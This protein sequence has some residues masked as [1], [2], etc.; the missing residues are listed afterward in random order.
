MVIDPNHVWGIDFT[1]IRL[2]NSWMCLVAVLD[3]YSRFVVSWELDQSLEMPFVVTAVDRALKQAVP[4][5]WNSDQGSHFTSSQY[6]DWLL[7]A[8][9]QIRMDGKG[10]AIDN[11]FAERLWRSPKYEEVYLKDYA[12][13][14]STVEKPVFGG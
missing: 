2:R 11:I 3:W 12:S 1:C 4:Q 5:I 9:V 10:R 14:R 13:A 6:I 7:A 8:N